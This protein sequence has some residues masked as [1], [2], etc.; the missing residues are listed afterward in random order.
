[1]KIRL[2][3]FYQIRFFKKNMIPMSTALSDPEWYHD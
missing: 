2:S 3:Y 1:M